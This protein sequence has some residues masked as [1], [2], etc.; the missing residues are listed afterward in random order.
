[1]YLSGYSGNP[2]GV[3][4]PDAVRERPRTG[5]VS[6]ASRI[7]GLAPC[8]LTTFLALFSAISG[9]RA[10]GILNADSLDIES[11]GDEDSAC[12]SDGWE[13]GKVNMGRTSPHDAQE[14]LLESIIYAAR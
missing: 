13:G 6:R 3:L 8:V 10:A 2:S 5:D 11:S 4:H 1:M 9:A 12:D 7:V 14:S